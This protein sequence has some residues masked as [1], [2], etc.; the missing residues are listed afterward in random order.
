MR[1]KL[2]GLVSALVLSFAAMS[3]AG[4]IYVDATDGVER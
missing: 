4:I 1:K 3:R 2:I